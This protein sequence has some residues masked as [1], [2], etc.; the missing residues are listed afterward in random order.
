[1]RS[2][3]LVLAVVL[4]SS[5]LSPL[6][7]RADPLPEGT[8]PTLNDRF[9]I[10][11]VSYGT[12]LASPTRYQKALQSGARWN[13]WVAYWYDIE[14]EPGVFDFTAYDRTIEADISH[15]LKLDVVLMGAPKFYRVEYKGQATT[16]P[17]GIDQPVFDDGTDIP[18]PD[19]QANPDNPWATFVYTMASRYQGKVGV[20][21]IW[22]E[23]DFSYFWNT[24]DDKEVEHYVR[25]LQVAYLVAKAADPSAII[26]IGGMMY[27]EWAVWKHERNAW[28][29]AFLK[30]LS[31]DPQRQANNF[32]FDVLPWHWYAMP[33][34]LYEVVTDGRAL[35][36]HYGIRGKHLWLNEANLPVC[37]DPYVPGKTACEKLPFYG[38]SKEQSAYLWQLFALGFAAGLERIFVFQLYD[39]GAGERG[40]RFGL[41][42]LDNSQREAYTT[43]QVAT[44]HFRDIK[45]VTR[46]TDAA[47]N[48]VTIVTG[49]ER[50]VVVW[51]GTQFNYVANLW[52][53]GGNPRV[54]KED[55]TVSALS[56][57]QNGVARLVLP[58]RLRG[59]MGLLGVAPP[60]NS[61]Y[62]MVE[63]MPAK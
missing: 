57:T 62:L 1:M 23:P 10:V 29:K 54:I 2:M 3:Q 36:E 6:P 9:G 34:E 27:W 48:S 13:R 20:W 32:Y 47:A 60:G 53:T 42:R 55:G 35:L 25:L 58:G 12:E 30:E 28:L 26:A 17:V 38:N 63:D 52:A 37:G 33:E 61:T 24:G 18:G 8:A 11:H 43:F 16:M 59:T 45:S 40:E 7:A 50:L 46:G 21:E 15:N 39:D 49:N 51:N 5:L 4:M 22:N 56:R 19:K 31:K 44:R 41:V 14:A